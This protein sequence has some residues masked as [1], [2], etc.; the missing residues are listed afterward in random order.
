VAVNNLRAVDVA[1]PARSLTVVTGVSGSGK[2]S[3]AFDAL[4]SEGQHRYAACLST[5]ARRFMRQA[6]RAELTAAEGLS[7]VVALGQ[8]VPPRNP[9]STVGTLTGIYDLYRLL[10]SRAGQVFGGGVSSGPGMTARLFSFNHLQGACPRCRGLGVVTR[11]DPERLVTHPDL[12]LTAGALGGHRTGAHYGD[13]DGQHVAILRAVGRAHGIDFERPWRE[14]EEAA[15]R[16]AMRGTGDQT[17]EVV[18]RYQR[19]RGRGARGAG[20]DPGL[21]E[22]EHRWST[23]WRGFAALVDEEYERKH[24]DRRGEAMRELM[25][26]RTCEAC[27]GLRLRPEVLAVR[28]A[29]RS[30]GEL[31]ALP[32]SAAAALLREEAGRSHA[33]ALLAGVLER[34]QAL[35]RVGLSYLALDRAVSTLSGGEVQRV[36]LA[37]QLRGALQDVIY[38]LD[39]PTVGLHP[40]DTARLIE[41]LQQLRDEGNTVVVVEHDLEVIRAADHVIDL[42][43][44]AGAE[45]GRVVAAGTPRE[46][47]RCR[48]SVTGRYLRGEGAARRAVERVT[49]GE[50]IRVRQAR[51]NNLRG[52]DLELPCR[53]LVAITGVSGSGKSSL[54]F[55]VLAPTARRGRPVACR[56]VEGLERFGEVVLVHRRPAGGGPSSTLASFVPGL[57]DG[58]RQ[59]FART[60]DARALGLTKRHFALAA[61]GGRCEACQGAG[62]TRVG[63]GFLADVHVT[64]EACGGLRY[65]ARTLRCRLEGLNVAEVL[66]LTV[67]QAARR[68]DGEGAGARGRVAGGLRLLAELGLG[69]LRLGQQ[70]ATLSGGEA[71]RLRLVSRLAARRGEGR[72]PGLL[73]L[74]EPTAGLHPRDVDMLVSLLRRLVEAGDTLL[75][76]EHDLELIR[77]ADWVVD[78][79]PEG[80]DGGGEV[81]ARGPPGEIARSAAASHTGAALARVLY[82]AAQ[83]A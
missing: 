62:W 52:F 53:C 15:R 17:Y 41:T 46:V 4:V 31:S 26:D 69:Y 25:V 58:I 73:L 29:G 54:L 42:G 1:I 51:A 75:V 32:V 68:F 9:R 40:R 37:S 10:Y 43:P 57:F 80:G 18:W 11:C 76:I 3:L 48:H 49:P 60:P 38:V 7:P 66:D 65:E 77:R 34:L 21:R 74:D 55:D 8:R 19:R 14:L 6:R 83:P 12:P 67:D 72:A 63:L 61:R 71:Q 23:P 16:V 36:R 44:G 47:A 20:G 79:G 39:E 13:P 27:R 70:C 56:S 59:L 30:I 2:S 82:T 35:E 45:G 24:A 78:L 22:G 64:C 28:F 50:W 5:Y 33:P 81:V